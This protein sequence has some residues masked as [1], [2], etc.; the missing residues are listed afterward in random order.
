[1]ELNL[2]ERSPCFTHLSA[3]TTGSI[4][5]AETFIV[6][7]LS[8]YPEYSGEGH[9]LISFYDDDLLGPEDLLLIGRCLYYV[10][11]LPTLSRKPTFTIVA[12]LENLR[13]F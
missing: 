13:D 11:S 9:T 2:H 6:R 7:Y 1:L 10:C 12:T 3:A 4:D 5:T 8:H